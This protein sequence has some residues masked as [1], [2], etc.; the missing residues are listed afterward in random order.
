MTANKLFWFQSNEFYPF[1]ESYAGKFVPRIAKKIHDENPNA[2]LKINLAGLGIGDG[3]MS[4]QDSSIYAEYLFQAGLVGETERDDLLDYEADMKRQCNAGYFRSAWEVLHKLKNRFN[5]VNQHL[6]SCYFFSPLWYCLV[7]FGLFD[8]MLVASELH[9]GLW[10]ISGQ[11][12]TFL[13]NF[14]QF[15]STFSSF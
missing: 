6:L 5:H 1:G 2:D 13:A 11:F 3:F 4:P 14:G 9:F 10:S 7:F 15:M 12:W 8:I